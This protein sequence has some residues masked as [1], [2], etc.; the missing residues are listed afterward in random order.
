MS[1]S[2]EFVEFV[3]DQIRDAGDISFR[4]MFGE[5]AVYCGG[6]VV[7]LICD[8]QVFIKPTD[9]GRS[10]IGQVEEA[11]PY[12]GA[13]PSFLIHEQLEDKEWMSKLVR[14]TEKELPEPKPKRDKSSKAVGK[15]VK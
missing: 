7:L 6:K 1:S 5:Y 15:I 14:L 11:Q 9:A 13:R 3:V 8:D 10:F 12:P 4:K 2:L